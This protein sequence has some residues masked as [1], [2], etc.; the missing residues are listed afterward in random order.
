MNGGVYNT[1]HRY[2]HAHGRELDCQSFTEAYN[3]G[4]HRGWK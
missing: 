2:V 1:R 3:T 4:V